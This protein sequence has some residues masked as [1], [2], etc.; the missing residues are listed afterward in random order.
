MGIHNS[1]YR[2]AIDHHQVCT[3]AADIFKLFVH[4]VERDLPLKCRPPTA[5]VIATVTARSVLHDV[6]YILKVEI[7]SFWDCDLKVG[8]ETRQLYSPY[9]A[10][11]AQG[12]SDRNPPLLVRARKRGDDSKS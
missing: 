4:H 10:L 1:R 9:G 5:R 7:F 11:G 3:A 6:L 8:I 12:G 2:V